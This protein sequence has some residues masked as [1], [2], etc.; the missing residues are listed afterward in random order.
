MLFI[1]NLFFGTIGVFFKKPRYCVPSWN[2]ELS[3][4]VFGI[5]VT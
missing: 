4:A 3:R 5:E 1:L 2:N